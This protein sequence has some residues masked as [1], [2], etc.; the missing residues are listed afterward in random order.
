MQSNS[1]PFYRWFKKPSNFEEHPNYRWSLNDPYTSLLDNIY[2]EV[3]FSRVFVTTGENPILVS[4]N[5]DPY[6]QSFVRPQ[7]NKT[8]EWKP[9]EPKPFSYGSLIGGK[10]GTAIDAGINLAKFIYQH[11]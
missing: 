3:P 7:K 11:G 8:E 5:N 1:Q 9:T 4:G 2:V 10:L 6:K